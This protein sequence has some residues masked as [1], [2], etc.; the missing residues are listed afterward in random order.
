[1]IIGIDKSSESSLDYHQCW[2]ERTNEE[3]EENFYSTCRGARE[4]CHATTTFEY[5]AAAL[6]AH[7]HPYFTSKYLQESV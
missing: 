7:H 6:L 4:Q 1:M 3:R 2:M 5:L